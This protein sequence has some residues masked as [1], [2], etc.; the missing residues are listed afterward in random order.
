MHFNWKIKK[1]NDQIWSKTK[2]NYHFLAAFNSNFMR[3][4]GLSFRNAFYIWDQT[5]SWKCIENSTR[6]KSNLYNDAHFESVGR[7]TLFIAFLAMDIP[8][9]YRMKKSNFFTKFSREKKTSN[10]FKR[11]PIKWCSRHRIS[12]LIA[13]INCKSRQQYSRSHW[14]KKERLNTNA[15]ALDKMKRVK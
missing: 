6:E 1:H 3:I 4:C 15:F 5:W 14:T 10:N 11:K 8:N 2:Q 7:L 12:L 9:A 13:T